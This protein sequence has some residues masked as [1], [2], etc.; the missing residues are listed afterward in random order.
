MHITRSNNDVSIRRIAKVVAI[1]VL[2]AP[3]TPFPFDAQTG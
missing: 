3:N 1:A 2:K